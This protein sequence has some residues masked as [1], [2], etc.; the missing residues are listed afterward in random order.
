MDIGVCMRAEILAD[1]LQAQQQDNTE[2]AWNLSR[3]P[4]GFT[5]EGRHHLFVASQGAWRGYF[6][7]SSEALFSP[8][9][10]STPYTLL[11]DTRTWTPIPAVPVKHFRGFTYNVPSVDSTAE[12]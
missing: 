4:K 7:L 11:F 3:W 12:A 6:A 2:Q 8:N 9:D 10:P 5:K 1:K